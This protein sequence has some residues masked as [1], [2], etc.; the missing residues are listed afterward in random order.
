MA[1]S[2][3]IGDFVLIKENIIDKRVREALLNN[4][5]RTAIRWESYR[6]FRFRIAGKDENNLII[7]IDA[8]NNE[9]HIS[10]KHLLISE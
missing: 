2:V 1:V 3:K 7:L 5:N 6:G 8:E 4:K 9:L 10:G